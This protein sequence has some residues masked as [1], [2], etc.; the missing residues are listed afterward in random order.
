M[1]YVE[2]RVVQHHSK[3]KLGCEK[4]LTEAALAL[5]DAGYEDALKRAQDLELKHR[6]DGSPRPWNPYTNVWELIETIRNGAE[7]PGSGQPFR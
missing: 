3:E 7:Q 1:A 6:G 2:R 5:L 4:S